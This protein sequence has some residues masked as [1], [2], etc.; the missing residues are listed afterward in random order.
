MK[1]SVWVF[2]IDGTLFDTAPYLPDPAPPAGDPAWD[3]FVVDS[4]NAKPI[5]TTHRLLRYLKNNG[6]LIVVLTGREAHRKTPT[7]ELLGDTINF[8]D[9]LMMRPTGDYSS[10]ADFKAKY[11]TALFPRNSVVLVDDDPEI[12][13][14]FLQ[15]GYRALLI[16]Q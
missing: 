10:P 1:K 3:K 9:A 12:V 4:R 13:N 15:L 11:V 5:E 7:L 16:L 8:V 14:R 2:D 6:H